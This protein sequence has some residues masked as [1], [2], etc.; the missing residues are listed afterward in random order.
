[1]NSVTYSA[2]SQRRTSVAVW[3]LAIASVM[4]WLVGSAYEL[5]TT[6]PQH[7]ATSS[8][9]AS[10]GTG[11]VAAHEAGADQPLEGYWAQVGR[12]LGAL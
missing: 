1:M 12:A 8:Q 11:R 5:R 6:S 2:A 10:V 3:V 4:L 9:Q 7:A